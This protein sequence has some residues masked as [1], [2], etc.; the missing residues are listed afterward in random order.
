MQDELLTQ[1]EELS[2]AG[3]LD[4][5]Q[6]VLDSITEKDGRF[7]FV[8]SKVYRARK[9]LNEERKQLEIAIEKEPENEEYRAAMEQLEKL[10][11]ESRIKEK[12]EKEKREKESLEDSEKEVGFCCAIIEAIIH[13]LS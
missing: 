13:F 10:V 11:E 12:E 9:W 8:Q 3:F 6:E 2:E 5:A 4:A 7:H 1:A